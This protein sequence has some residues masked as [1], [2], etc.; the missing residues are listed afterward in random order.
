MWTAWKKRAGM[1]S[2]WAAPTCQ[3]TSSL[4]GVGLGL[5]CLVKGAQQWL[6]SFG[7][8]LRK[9]AVV[10]CSADFLQYCGRDGSGGRYAVSGQGFGGFGR[11][12]WEGGVLW[13]VFVCRAKST[14]RFGRGWF[15]EFEGREGY[16]LV[17]R[18]L[19]RRC[20][21]RWP[22]FASDTT[23]E[24]QVSA[25][26]WNLYFCYVLQGLLMRSTFGGFV[27]NALFLLLHLGVAEIAVGRVP[28]LTAT[29]ESGR[30]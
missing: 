25:L 7:S 29:V 18:A 20:R 5:A 9:A 8:R 6:S 2:S 11:G 19:E 16:S 26:P 1:G 3:L 28:T 21:R 22:L 10:C 4:C 15:S 12:V 13:K 30:C 27:P 24:P 14:L 17:G 23:L